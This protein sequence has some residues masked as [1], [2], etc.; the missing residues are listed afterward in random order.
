MAATATPQASSYPYH[1]SRQIQMTQ[2]GGVSVA[3]VPPRGR[4]HDSAAANSRSVGRFLYGPPPKIVRGFSQLQ[5]GGA[6]GA[7]QQ[8]RGA[9]SISPGQMRKSN[10]A[11][12][13]GNKFGPLRG[14]VT[15]F[16]GGGGTSATTYHANA[17]GGGAGGAQSTML[18]GQPRGNIGIAAR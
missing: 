10:S 6:A 17:A 13:V 15:P 12:H 8:Q 2:G 5:G 4:D 9:A 14:L 7:A 16:L 18:N 1:E 11:A 3:V